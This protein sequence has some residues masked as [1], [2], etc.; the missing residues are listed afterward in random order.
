MS[1]KKQKTLRIALFKLTFFM[2]IPGLLT[3]CSF[4]TPYKAPI[5]QGT[6]INQEA[7]K[8]LQPGLTVGQVR[9]LLGPPLGQN[10]FYPRHWEYVFYTTDKNFH[11][12]A[13]KHLIV[14]FDREGYLESWEM[15][16]KEVKI[17][18]KNR[19]SL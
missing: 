11:P 7:I 13:A 17:R 12:D 19:V 15:V 8:T 14:K 4:F 2:A 18:Q 6:I 16:D 9:Q 1:S 5:T 10:P 3:G